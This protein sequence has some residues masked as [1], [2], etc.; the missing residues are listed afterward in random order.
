MM[1]GPA[2][3]GPSNIHAALF[4]PGQ[5]GNPLIIQRMGL[6]YK[7]KEGKKEGEKRKGKEK[8]SRKNGGRE[9]EG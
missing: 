3:D 8:E 7:K 2:L 1:N 9:E 4:V 5:F 6:L